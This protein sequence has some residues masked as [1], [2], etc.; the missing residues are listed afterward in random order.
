M[1]LGRARKEVEGVVTRGEVD[2]SI[3]GLT[4]QGYVRGCFSASSLSPPPSRFSRAMDKERPRTGV[5]SLSTTLTSVI[6]LYHP[7]LTFL[8]FSPSSS[9]FPL[10]QQI[11]D[12][13]PPEMRRH[14]LASRHEEMRGGASPRN[15]VVIEQT[16]PVLVAQTLP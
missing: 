15:L 16:V 2:G 4:V 14:A 7:S 3:H 8:S 12:G 13:N 9:T 10:F 5:A 1:A 11:L 6:P